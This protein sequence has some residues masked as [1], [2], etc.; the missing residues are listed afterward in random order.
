MSF[1]K[2]LS[3]TMSIQIKYYNVYDFA[4]NKKLTPMYFLRVYEAYK[5]KEKNYAHVN[6][7]D[8]QCLSHL[9]VQQSTNLPFLI[10]YN[11]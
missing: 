7:N 9:Y 6:Q 1:F 8:V 2:S 11:V 10:K 5:Y 4:V 3:L